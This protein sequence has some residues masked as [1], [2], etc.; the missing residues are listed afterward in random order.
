MK[1]GINRKPFEKKT[2]S[3]SQVVVNKRR[4]LSLKI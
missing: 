1:L 3:C 2:V 4:V